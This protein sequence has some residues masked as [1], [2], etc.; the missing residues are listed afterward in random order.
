VKNK[1]LVQ[2]VKIFEILYNNRCNSLLRTS[3]YTGFSRWNC[4]GFD[5]DKCP[6]S[7]FHLKHSSLSAD[8]VKIFIF[9]SFFIAHFLRVKNTYKNPYS[10][11]AVKLWQ[12]S[13]R[14]TGSFGGDTF[15]SRNLFTLAQNEE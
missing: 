3:G 11:K 10:L 13:A 8:T 9:L 2:I 6:A 12:I 1:Y 14:L 15:Q 7:S 5:P 4:P